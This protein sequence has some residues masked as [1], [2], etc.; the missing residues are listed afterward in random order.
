M[1]ST[2]IFFI[3]RLLRFRVS[4][5]FCHPYF[6]YRA[7]AAVFV[8]V[9]HPADVGMAADHVFTTIPGC[10]SS[11]VELEPELTRKLENVSC[12]EGWR[13]D[14]SAS[15]IHLGMTIIRSRLGESAMVARGF[16]NSLI[17]GFLESISDQSD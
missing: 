11:H 13:A 1:C 2:T 8:I 17:T 15:V 10:R 16:D 6:P 3:P 12:A 4:S 14:T 7:V 9:L 5:I